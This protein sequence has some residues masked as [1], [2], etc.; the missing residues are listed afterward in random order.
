MHPDG[1]GCGVGGRLEVGVLACGSSLN[2]KRRS[3][4]CSRQPSGQNLAKGKGF[5]L[6][7]WSVLSFYAAVG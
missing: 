1:F 7:F 5:G 2:Q 4:P 6:H 3:W